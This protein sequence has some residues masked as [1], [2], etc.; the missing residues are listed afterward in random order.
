MSVFLP[1]VIVFILFSVFVLL[2]AEWRQRA[3]GVKQ[4]HAEVGMLNLLPRATSGTITPDLLYS[5]PLK[6]CV[7][8]CV[9]VNGCVSACLSL[10][11]S[12]CVRSSHCVLK[13][14]I[15]GFFVG[16]Y[17]Y[18]NVLCVSLSLC[19]CHCAVS[20][21][22]H[23]F[24]L[25]GSRGWWGWLLCVYVCSMCVSTFQSAVFLIV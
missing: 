12:L 17:L 16:V 4:K 2:P 10:Y 1:T 13:C 6:Q 9:F 11:E 19:P 22:M 15:L 8:V 21:C 23:V 24:V 3:A 25:H 5:A 20:V 14:V 7:C 18:V